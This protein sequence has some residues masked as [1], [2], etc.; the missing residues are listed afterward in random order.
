M[1][2]IA[3]IG[4]FAVAMLFLLRKKKPKKGGNAAAAAT[5]AGG[6]ID[7][8]APGGRGSIV[9]HNPAYQQQLPHQQQPESVGLVQYYDQKVAEGSYAQGL[10]YP[11]NTAH[12]YPPQG[13]TQPQMAYPPQMSPQ[14][15]QGYAWPPQQQQQPPVP[16]QQVPP[17]QQQQQFIA[18]MPA[19]TKMLQK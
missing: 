19:D 5:V 12:P 11:P 17:P 9:A 2:G 10:Q 14:Q 6:G 15:L 8:N 7:P 4:I 3:V 13:P 1:G 18:E 16:Q